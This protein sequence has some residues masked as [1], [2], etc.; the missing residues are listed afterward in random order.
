VI[1][2]VLNTP[3]HVTVALTGA[4]SGRTVGRHCVRKTIHNRH[5]HRCH[6][7]VT[8]GTLTFAGGYAGHNAITFL[9]RLSAT[10]RLRTGRYG[11]T[12]AAQNASGKASVPGASFEIV[13]H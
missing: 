11:F 2:F 3:A 13:K 9:G 6:R 8:V 10:H 1:G 5:A 12:V 7:T 4:A